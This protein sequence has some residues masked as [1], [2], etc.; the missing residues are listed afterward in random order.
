MISFEE[1]KRIAELILPFL[2]KK[3]SI[4]IIVNK[5]KNQIPYSVQSIYSWLDNKYLPGI[6]NV[7]K[8]IKINYTTRKSKVKAQDNGKDYLQHT[9]YEEFENYIAEHP[10]DEV[11]ELDTV[12]GVNNKS[13]IVTML[14]RKSNYMM[15]FKVPDYTSI[16]VVN[17]FNNIKK[18]LGNN[19]FK[20]T[21]KVILID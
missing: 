15:A 11:V 8:L 4:D 19:L 5:M 1:R 20:E 14:F 7:H 17:V 18:R 16:S 2:K 9:F 3:V 6:D 21:L 13:Y 10:H 12:E